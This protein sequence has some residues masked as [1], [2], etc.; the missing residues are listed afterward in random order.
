MSKAFYTYVLRDPDGSPFY[1]GKGCGRRAWSRAGRGQKLLARMSQPHSVEIISA[2]T[3]AAAFQ[4]EIALIKKYGLHSMG[5]PLLNISLGG[6]GCHGRQSE[7]GR[8]AISRSMC[9]NTNR[10]GKS[11]TKEELERISTGVKKTL[12]PERLE[13]LRAAGLKGSQVSKAL[14]LNT[15]GG[16][17]SGAFKPGNVPHNANGGYHF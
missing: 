9:G 1:V 6:Y 12:T 13:Q 7:N 5:G 15:Q 3:E 2:E 4:Q 16:K 10:R 14:G 11:F 8:N 17:H